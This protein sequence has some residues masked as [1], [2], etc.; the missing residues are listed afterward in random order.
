MTPSRDEKQRNLIRCLLEE[1]TMLQREKYH[2]IYGEV[3][4]TPSAKLP[5]AIRLCLRT[6]EANWK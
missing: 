4:T 2:M 1:C 6:V 5:S 3:A